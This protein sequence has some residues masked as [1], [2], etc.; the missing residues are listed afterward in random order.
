MSNKSYIEE[1]MSISTDGQTHPY[2]ASPGKGKGDGNIQTPK[3]SA[4]F[5]SLLARVNLPPRPRA[6]DEEGSVD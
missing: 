2:K 5:N 6:M 4:A 1:E 3:G